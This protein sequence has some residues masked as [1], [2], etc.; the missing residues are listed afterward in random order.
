MIYYGI[1]LGNVEL[2]KKSKDAAEAKEIINQA[3]KNHK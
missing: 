1:V 3:I 2:I